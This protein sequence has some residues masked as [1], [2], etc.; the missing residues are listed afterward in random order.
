MPTKV[1]RTTMMLMT[2][3]LLL[4]VSVSDENEQTDGAQRLHCSGGGLFGV[5]KSTFYLQRLAGTLWH[6][7]GMSQSVQRDFLALTKSSR[8]SDGKRSAPTVDRNRLCRGRVGG[9]GNEDRKGNP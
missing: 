5:W 7:G 2:A 3:D 9:G 4:S 1:V 8:E 6:S